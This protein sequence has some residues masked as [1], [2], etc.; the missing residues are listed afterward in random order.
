MTATWS[1]RSEPHQHYLTWYGNT[2]AL[3]FTQ[4]CK[5]PKAPFPDTPKLD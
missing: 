1:V 4:H 5:K 2:G 3:G